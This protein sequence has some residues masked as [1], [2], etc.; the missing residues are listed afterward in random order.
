MFD[1]K[2]TLL[3]ALIAAIAGASGGA[4]ITS[5]VLNAEHSAQIN[6]MRLEAEENIRIAANKAIQ[7]ERNA[8]ALALKLEVQNAETRKQLDD[9]L[10]NNR[11]LSRELGGLRDPFATP[12]SC[13]LSTSESSAS[14][15]I[16]N[17]TEGRLS[18]E[19]SEFLLEYAREADR[20]A[21]YANTCYEW[22]RELNG[23]R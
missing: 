3:A 7:I 12:S 4:L 2:M 1:I 13:P 8:N 20:A 10:S 23:R 18:N 21:E 16:T 9:V 5:D 15:A 17:A 14:V 6:L 19:A 11:R 22:I